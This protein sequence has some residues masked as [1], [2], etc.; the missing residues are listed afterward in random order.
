MTD[1]FAKTVN[2]IIS[3]MYQAIS[4]VNTTVLLIDSSGT[5]N[6]IWRNLSSLEQYMLN[7]AVGEEIFKCEP[8]SRILMRAITSECFVED[9][10][11]INSGESMA[12]LGISIHVEDT[13]ELGG[14]GVFMPFERENIDS[15][16]GLIKI[17]AA[18]LEG[19]W[20]AI[21]HKRNYEQLYRNF[22]GVMGTLSA[23][24][25]VTDKNLAVAHIN[26][27]AVK[28]LR[29]EHR[30]LIGENI[31]LCLHSGGMFLPIL[32]NLQDNVGTKRNIQLEGT[33]IE[34]EIYPIYKGAAEEDCEGL[35]IKL[36]PPRHLKLDKR[37]KRHM[38]VHFHFGDIHGKSKGI[39]EAIRLGKIASE[40]L[41]NVLILGE[42]GTGKELF[43]QAIHNYSVR[44]EGP[45]VTV[46]CGALREELVEYELLGCEERMPGGADIMGKQ[47]KFE[48]ANGGTLFLDE[49]GDMSADSQAILLRVLQNQEIVRTGGSKKIKVNVR[50]IAATN[51]NMDQLV[52]E[53]KFRGDLYYR[54]N[55]F[56]LNLPSLADRKEDILLLS[57]YFIKNYSETLGKPAKRLSSDVAK[58]LFDY[59]WP[60]NIRELKNVIQ[61][62]VNISRENV[63]LPEDLP[64]NL[65]SFKAGKSQ[66]GMS[67]TKVIP[68][69][70][71]L[72]KVQQL[73][74]NAIVEALNKCNGNISKTAEFLGLNRRTLYRR[75][76][77]Y[78]IDAKQYKT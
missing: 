35:I 24:I 5:I 65:Q 20:R 33:D 44:R 70:S 17:T 62:A 55:V 11:K 66:A 39:Q 63:I 72:N 26:D 43:A 1:E 27:A 51:R 6:C 40:S 46:N 74:K 60:G 9:I 45:F 49:I 19:Q 75:M 73:E 30:E 57:D 16:R 18:T 8:S 41:S 37:S 4:N 61:R 77:N 25:V 34:C 52:Q 7:A 67:K 76:D 29:L 22:S 59:D 23:G 14:L 10:V 69:I 28:L 21:Y 64:L 32:Q 36:N 42:S 53:H 54:L 13:E 31:D 3:D 12:I 50:I 38:G 78:G 47:G 2:R 58:L 56:T 68:K 71:S 48:Q 15:A